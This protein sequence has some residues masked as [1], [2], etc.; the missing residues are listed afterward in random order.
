MME[1]RKPRSPGPP[2]LTELCSGYVEN[3]DFHHQA[4][5]LNFIAIPT[6]HPSTVGYLKGKFAVPNSSSDR[7]V[8]SAV[9]ISAQPFSVLRAKLDGIRF[10]ENRGL[11]IGNITLEGESMSQI[12]SRMRLCTPRSGATCIRCAD[13]SSI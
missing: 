2:M 4:A 13:V 7:I 5:V 12:Q 1:M 11:S 3:Y 6:S 9:F 8:S 10:Q